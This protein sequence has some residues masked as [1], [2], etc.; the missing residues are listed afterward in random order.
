MTLNTHSSASNLLHVSLSAVQ[1]FRGC[2]QHY[3]YRHVERLQ[4]KGKQTAPL[5]GTMLH[6]YLEHYYRALQ[7]G[8]G[9]SAT[10]HKQATVHLHETFSIVLGGL[11]QLTEGRSDADAIESAKTYRVLLDIAIRICSRYYRTR[12]KQDAI[13]YEILLVE[14]RLDVPMF[15]GKVRSIGYVDMVTRHR[16]TGRINLWEHKSTSSVPSNAYRLR[17][18]Q[19]PLY[20]AK[21]KEL[22]LA[23]NIDSIIWN[24]IRTKEPA[25]PQLLKSGK[26]TTKV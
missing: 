17:D 22:E 19:T 8:R 12:G 18:L 4:L 24:Y 20:A 25:I 6:E 2:E 23:P 5:L 11:T 16:E 9:D 21:I 26:L 10:L 15:K 7:E 14:K 1:D 13:E 3:Y